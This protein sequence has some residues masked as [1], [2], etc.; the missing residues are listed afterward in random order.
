MTDI[1]YRFNMNVF[2]EKVAVIDKIKQIGQ[3]EDVDGTE[4]YVPAEIGDTTYSPD[5]FIHNSNR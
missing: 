1:R 4:P 2:G 3:T 5:G